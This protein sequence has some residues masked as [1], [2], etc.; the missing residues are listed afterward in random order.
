M[1]GNTIILEVDPN[2]AAFI[3]GSTVRM[4]RESGNQVTQMVGLR[5]LDQLADRAGL[6]DNE[7]VEQIVDTAVETALVLIGEVMT[8]D[9]AN[10]QQATQAETVM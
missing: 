2:T 5:L 3:A 6:L 1:N 7:E 8:D 10:V 9:F 4:L